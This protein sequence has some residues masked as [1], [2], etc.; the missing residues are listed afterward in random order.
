MMP[1][2]NL[3]NSLPLIAT[4]DHLKKEGTTMPDIIRELTIAAAP[5]RVWNALTQPGEIGQWWTNESP[6][7]P[8]GRLPR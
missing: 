4:S 8:G 5:E 6:C 7:H 1:L 2:A 3:F